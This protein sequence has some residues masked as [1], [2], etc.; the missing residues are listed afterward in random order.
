[1]RKFEKDPPEAKEEDYI[2]LMLKH[3]KKIE[4][5]VKKLNESFKAAENKFK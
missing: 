2:N 4:K 5:A 1:M 3:D